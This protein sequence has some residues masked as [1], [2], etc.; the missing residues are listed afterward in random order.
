MV[1]FHSHCLPAMD[2][3]A[4]DR[5]ESIAMLLES[6]RQ[7]VD[8]VVATS[9]YYASQEDVDTFLSRREQAVRLLGDGVPD[10]MLLR[11]GAE[12]LLQEGLSARDLQPLC[13]EGTRHILIELPF[14]PPM[15]WMYEELEN[16]ALGQRLD[17]IL[18]HTDR[19]RPWYSREKIAA[20]ADLPALTLQINAEAITGYADFHRLRRWLPPAEGLVFG[21]DMHHSD[22]RAPNL[23]PVYRRL[24]RY[25]AGR[26]WL[27]LA[28][29]TAAALLG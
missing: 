22:H 1:D 5:A 19:Y 4:C 12:V 26:Q 17:I 7:G 11:L 23:Q 15:P 20:M 3:G 24:R 25:A 9:H 14:M 2:D 21:S 28:E 13:I 8:T 10:G 27:A 16:I 6:K 18:A 29:Q